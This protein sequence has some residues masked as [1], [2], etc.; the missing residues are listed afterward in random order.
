[1]C[2]L[3]AGIDEGEA[4][5]ETFVDAVEDGLGASK[6]VSPPQIESG[7]SFESESSLLSA[8]SAMACWANMRWVCSISAAASAN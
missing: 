5:T 3:A 8:S 7:R 4:E 2:G 1:L 6:P